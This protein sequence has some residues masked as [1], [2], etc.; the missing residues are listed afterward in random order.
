LSIEAEQ[1]APQPQKGK[2]W[3]RKGSIAASLFWLTVGWLVVALLATGFLLTDL[4][5]R[6]LDTT[7]S[8]TLDFHVESLAGILLEAGDP[9]DP[10][11]ALADPRFDRPRSGWYWIIRDGEGTLVN[12]STSVVGIDLPQLS[13]SLD[14]TGRR[15]GVVS[16]AF[17]TQLRVVER[18]V[19]LDNET[20]RIGQSDR[21]SRPRRRVSGA[22]FHRARRRGGDAGDHERDRGAFCAEA[23]RQAERGHR[24]RARRRKH[25]GHGALSHRNC[26]FGR[27]GQ[28]TAA[29]ECADH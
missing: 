8:Q 26:A 15:T 14:S 28:R 2:N 22:D 1:T 12:L 21:N 5:S 17:G 16:D 3:L 6:A 10:D 18:S 20:Y 27:G 7:L 9:R 13:G 11:I 25:R 24:K 19:T 29:F 23:D 4:Y